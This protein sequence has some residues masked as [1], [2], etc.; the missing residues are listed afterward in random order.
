[1]QSIMP[2]NCGPRQEPWAPKRA[3]QP[4]AR[5]EYNL[6]ASP[7]APPSQGGEG[8]VGG[9]TRAHVLEA[10]RFASGEYNDRGHPGEVPH[11]CAHSSRNKRSLLRGSTP[12]VC[13]RGWAALDP[14]ECN[15]RTASTCAASPLSPIGRC[16]ASYALQM[17]QRARPPNRRLTATSPKPSTASNATTPSTRIPSDTLSSHGP[18]SRSSSS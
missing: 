5:G 3:R 16:C 6:C 1:M 18:D 14:V 12:A 10:G 7:L 13:T 9:R 17:W 15:R 8:L 4:L 2:M 11:R